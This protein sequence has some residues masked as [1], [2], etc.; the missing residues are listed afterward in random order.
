MTCSC[1]YNYVM[2]SL[3]AQ[4]SNR[5]RPYKT[6]MVVA[7]EDHMKYIRAEKKWLEAKGKEAKLKALSRS[8]RYTGSLMECPKCGRFSLVKPQNE[9]EC[10]ALILAAESRYP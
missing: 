9:D 6:Y 3:K 5:P 8:A 1:G 7:D 2:A 10:E 4:Q